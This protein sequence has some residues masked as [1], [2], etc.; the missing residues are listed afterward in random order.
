MGVMKHDIRFGGIV[1]SEKQIVIYGADVDEI[2]VRDVEAV[3]IPGRNGVLHLDN[4]RWMERTQTYHAFIKGNNYPARLGYARNT[5][6]RVG[7]AYTRLED[8]FN[9]DTYTL[10]TF[11]DAMI[12]ESLAFR[13]A[14]LCDLV[15]QCRPER[16][17]RTG[18]QTITT[19]SSVTLANPTG[20]PAKPLFRVYG[21]SGTLTVGNIA[22]TLTD[23][24]GYVDIDCEMGDCYKGSVNCNSKVTLEKFPTLD[25]GTTGVALSGSLTSVQITPRWWRL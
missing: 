5:F 9:P 18:D 19:T 12:P 15:F 17:L 21:T 25:E 8:T 10:A 3:E 14:G 24:D 7:K 23:I 11:A 4:G 22:L 16:Y 20:M 13:T 6:G 2:A 1:A